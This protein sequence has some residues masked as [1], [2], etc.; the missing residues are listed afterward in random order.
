M[1]ELRTIAGATVVAV[2]LALYLLGRVLRRQGRLGGLVAVVLGLQV[3]IWVPADIR[4]WTLAIVMAL[5]VWGGSEGAGNE[6][7]F[8]GLLTGAFILIV[9][10]LPGGTTA[11]ILSILGIV[12]FVRSRASLQHLWRLRRARSLMPGERSARDVEIGGRVGG[13]P[14]PAPM[15]HEI[16]CSWWAISVDDKR[17]TSGLLRLQSSA[18]TVLARLEDAEIDITEAHSKWTKCDDRDALEAIVGPLDDLDGES[19]VSAGTGAGAKGR[20]AG[21]SAAG[22][23]PGTDDGSE[24]YYTLTWLE[25]GTEV[26]VVGTPTWER[27]PA[28]MGGYR[29][30]PVVP[31]FTGKGVFLADKSAAD[32]RRDALFTM[33]NW[34]AWGVV[35]GVVGGL[36][37]AGVF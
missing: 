35:C 9:G 30:A 22:S 11:V 33:A 25:P 2:A 19:G 37:L 14:V 29:D 20:G 36:Q 16:A 26:Y 21:A 10:M 6:G 15:G 3:A 34:C 18:G 4:D 24:V 31:V 23:R 28:D 7:L 5:A 27:A 1:D 32:A 8:L 12:G 17:A 13:R